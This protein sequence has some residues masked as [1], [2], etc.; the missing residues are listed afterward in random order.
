MIDER[1]MN[2]IVRGIM[3]MRSFFAFFSITDSSL[4]IGI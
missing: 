1:I 3:I 2:I 4:M